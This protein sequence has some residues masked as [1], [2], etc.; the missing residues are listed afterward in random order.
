MSIRS[1]IEELKSIEIE[2]KRLN[3]ILNVWR[4]KR[5]QI[6]ERINEYLISKDQPGT[7][8]GDIA[9]IRKETE[10]YSTKGIKRKDKDEQIITFLSNKGIRNA[11]E[12]YTELYEIMKGPKVIE[13]QIKIQKINK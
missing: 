6:K 2:I 1:D 8:C 3:S 5:I 7:K 4:K 10:K 11:S 12:I 9:I 13:S